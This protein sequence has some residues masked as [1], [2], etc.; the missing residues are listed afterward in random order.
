M[1]NGPRVPYRICSRSPS[2]SHTSDSEDT[3]ANKQGYYNLRLTTSL[4][5]H[6]LL[7]Q[8]ILELESLVNLIGTFAAEQA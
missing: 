8:G 3:E 5:A 4:V 7:P 1:P 2:P 6:K